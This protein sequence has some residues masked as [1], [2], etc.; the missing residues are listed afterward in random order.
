LADFDYFP[1]KN[2]N[3]SNFI[4][5]KSFQVN[6]PIV[7]KKLNE[8]NKFITAEYDSYLVSPGECDIF[9]PTNFNHLQQVYGKMFNKESS[10]VKNSSFV[11]QHSSKEDLLM[12]QTKSGYNPMKEDYSNFSIFTSK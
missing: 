7:Q 3:F 12:T 10:F 8:Q 4:L 11:E 1:S 6:S 2:V 9:F 5:L